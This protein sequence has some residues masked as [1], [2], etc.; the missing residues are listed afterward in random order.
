ME[1]GADMHEKSAGEIFHT[2]PPLV[3][4]LI[5]WQNLPKNFGVVW[6]IFHA[7]KPEISYTGILKTW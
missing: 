1:T 6:W 7:N 2:L 4:C 3:A 5:L